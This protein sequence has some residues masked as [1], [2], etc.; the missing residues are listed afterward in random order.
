MHIFFTIFL[1][2]VF[3]GLSAE[4]ILDNGD[5]NSGETGWELSPASSI[6]STVYSTAANK[7][8]R[9]LKTVSQKKWDS[10]LK[11]VPVCGGLDYELSFSVKL[12]NALQSHVKIE[13]LTKNQT[14]LSTI[15]PMAGK[16]GTTDWFTIKCKIKA[17]EK[18]AIARI[19]LYSG[20]S[21]EKI[22]TTWFDEFSMIPSDIRKHREKIQNAPTISYFNLKKNTMKPRGEAISITRWS[23]REIVIPEQA[24]EQDKYGATLLSFL[25]K[26][27]FKSEFPIT[28]D[29]LCQKKCFI[30]IGTTKQFLNAKI[31]KNSEPQG[32]VIA[33]K[34]NN[35]FLNG[36]SRGAIYSVLALIQEDFG[37]RWYGANDPILVPELNSD[38]FAV[39]PRSGEP[40]F[41]MREP[42]ISEFSGRNEFNAF[43]RVQAVSYFRNFPVNMG[44]CLSNTNYFIHTYA[45]LIPAEKYFKSNPEY[46]PMRD[47]KR[48]P[49]KQTEGQLCYTNPGV[50]EE[51]AKQ[52]ETT[53]S[54][55]PG[56]R[57]YSVSQND[58]I[59]VNC[60]C[61]DCQTII[62]KDGISGAVL[63][64]ANRVAE[65][66]AQKYPDIRIT[67][68]A[69]GD[70]Q[71]IPAT[72]K[73]HPNTVIFYAPISDRAG[74]LQLTP[75]EKVPKIN[76]E[77]NGWCKSGG[78]V[79]IW[80][81]MRQEGP[82]P[83][84]WMLEENID[85]WK[86]TGVSGVFIEDLE[87]HLNSLGKLRNWVSMQKLWNT[88]WNMEDLIGE[89]IEGYYGNAAEEFKAYVRLLKNIWLKYDTSRTPEQ[90]FQFSQEDIK[91]MR[92]LLTRAYQKSPNEKTALELCSFY[93]LTL[94][95][96]TQ[97]N[98]VQYEKDLKHILHLLEKWELLLVSYSLN[99]HQEMVKSW[100][101]QLDEVKKGTSIPKYSEN[102]IILKKPDIARTNNK[103]VTDKGSLSGFPVRQIA[104]TDWEIQW[105]IG[106]LLANAVN[107]AT[108]VVRIR[109]KPDLKRT[110]SMKENIFS[111]HL[112][113]SGRSQTQGR[114][115]TRQE[116]KKDTWQ[117]IYLYKVYLFTPSIYGY[118]YNC[119]GNL[120]NGDAV[121]YDYIEFI[122]ESEF[123]EKDQIQNLKTI[124]L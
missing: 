20:G 30:S 69:Y 108:Y 55:N 103:F 124:T 105:P 81:Y 59:Y 114:F 86:N 83:D 31:N 58:N 123:K 112:Y 117:F 65:V 29:N 94:K 98:I 84:F 24:S 74:C 97:K 10:T 50:A 68:L 16:D 104:K 70:S 48:F 42:I 107:Q 96:C 13:W 25:L 115:V 72:I 45:S 47:G 41:E 17:P 121:I 7:N 26:K 64:L 22:G 2:F 57:I 79:Y 116:L 28:T 34:D 89:F 19:I 106:K 82:H 93:I 56:S 92:E 120:A 102:S 62:N 75:W 61:R 14:H 32:Y 88:E 51:I 122:P 78:K 119:T 87:H 36:G 110:Y 18:A 37:C 35:L 44:G 49:S 23:S 101:E 111:L 91:S 54:K 76:K 39:V 80:D 40:S 67:T 73:P 71:K 11:K 100:Q 52:L 38:S 113:C 3:T 95:H 66:L 85:Y 15:Y 99:E 6:D 4:N 33:V 77:L 27:I 43:N 46:F 5:F 118:F 21:S 12:H 63:I 1:L 60:E 53:I 9:S 90:V 109:V 8:C